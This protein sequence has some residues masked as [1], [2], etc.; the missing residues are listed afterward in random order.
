MKERKRGIEGE[1]ERERK[2]RKERKVKRR[3]EWWRERRD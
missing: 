2:E 1:G 3:R